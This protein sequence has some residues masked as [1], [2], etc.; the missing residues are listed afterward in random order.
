MNVL[1]VLGIVQRRA[2]GAYALLGAAA[3]PAALLRL[4]SED[5]EVPEGAAPTPH[6]PGVPSSDAIQT[7]ARAAAAPAAAEPGCDRTLAGLTK[8]FVLLFLA[9]RCVGGAAPVW[10]SGHVTLGADER[11]N[12]RLYDVASVMCAIGLVDKAGSGAYLWLGPAAAAAT[13]AKSA[14]AAPDAESMLPPPPVA[15]VLCKRPRTSSDA[16]A[17]KRGRLDAVPNLLSPPQGATPRPTGG[18]LIP[19]STPLT[20]EATAILSPLGQLPGVAVSA[21]KQGPELG[22]TLADLLNAARG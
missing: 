11:S 19:G 9:K 21:V 15:P 17:P 5:P 20:V 10:Q 7:V 14:T 6:P 16:P 1:E 4:V 12:R 13:L 8:R 18:T 22:L 2:K 3:L